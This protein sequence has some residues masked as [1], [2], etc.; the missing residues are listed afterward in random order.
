MKNSNRYKYPIRLFIFFAVLM[1]TFPGFSNT[2]SIALGEFAV[3]HTSADTTVINGTGNFKHLSSPRLRRPAILRSKKHVKR[4]SIKR[5]RKTPAFRKKRFLNTSNYHRKELYA[6]LGNAVEMKD[7]HFRLNALSPA[8]PDWKAAL[9]S[10]LQP[11]INGT[12]A[13]DS[14]LVLGYTDNTGSKKTNLSFSAKR[15]ARIMA[16]LIKQGIPE[17]RIH[18]VAMGEEAPVSSNGSIE[19]RLRNRRVEINFLR[20]S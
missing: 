12:E 19:G 16:Y 1:I 4:F 6:L 2:G 7:L 13:Y 5:S 10:V 8:A 9:D 18:T 3:D 11:Y 15:A 14:I 20:S 17:H